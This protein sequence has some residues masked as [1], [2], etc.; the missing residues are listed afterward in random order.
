MPSF[1]ASL[2]I[3]PTQSVEA[4]PT[5]FVTMTPSAW[6]TFFKRLAAIFE[7]RF[8][9]FASTEVTVIKTP[10]KFKSFPWRR[11]SS[12]MTGWF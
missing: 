10:A 7:T 2:A 9:C 1:S 11:I 5:P 4:P 8:L 12:T 3:A 6:R